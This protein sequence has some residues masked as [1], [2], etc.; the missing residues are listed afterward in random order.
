MATIVGLLGLTYIGSK[1]GDGIE[2]IGL[3]ILTIKDN[4]NQHIYEWKTQNE[5]EKR[6][7]EMTTIKKHRNEMK[8]KY[9]DN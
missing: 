9:I 8:E 1:I 2:H 5:R 7:I 6:D 4:I 3:K